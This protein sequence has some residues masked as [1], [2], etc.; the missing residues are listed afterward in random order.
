[1]DK[2]CQELLGNVYT[3]GAVQEAQFPM[4]SMDIKSV[5]KFIVCRSLAATQLHL[6]VLCK[7]CP[8]DDSDIP[9]QLNAE[10]YSSNKNALVH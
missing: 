3:A 10:R 5:A 6:C 4:L 7:S 2:G 1:M 8:E 9:S